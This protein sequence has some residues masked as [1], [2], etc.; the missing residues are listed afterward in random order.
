MP[1]FS[2]LI[3]FFR[4]NR[5]DTELAEE[6]RQ[7]LELRRAA[8]I[9]EGVSPAEADREARRQFGNV[10]AIRDRA[11]DEWGSPAAAAVLSPMDPPAFV[12]SVLF[13]M[14]AAAVAAWLP[15]RRAASVDPVLAL[16]SDG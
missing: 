15:A 14:A 8:L 3:A 12:A 6:I 16:R 7:H 1:N 2:R 10:T 4:R 13:V 9:D 5:L 11:R